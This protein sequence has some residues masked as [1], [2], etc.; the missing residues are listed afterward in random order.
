MSMGISSVIR[1]LKKHNINTKI[2]TAWKLVRGGGD[3]PQML[4]KQYF[5]AAQVYGFNNKIIYQENLSVIFLDKNG[6]K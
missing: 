1:M 3:I 4:W 2:S 6:K 5:I